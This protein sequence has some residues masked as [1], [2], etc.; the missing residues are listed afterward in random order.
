MD[1][2]RL[3]QC[4][5]EEETLCL[6]M[7]LGCI[8]VDPGRVPDVRGLHSTLRGESCN[9]LGQGTSLG[10]V[11]G[12]EGF[13]ERGRDQKDARVQGVV[14]PELFTDLR[15]SV[16]THSHFRSV[17]QIEAGFDPIVYAE[18]RLLRRYRIRGHRRKQVR[19]PQVIAHQEQGG[20]RH[21]V[22]RLQQRGAVGLLVLV[23]DDECELGLAL[24]L[25]EAILQL[26]G[27]V[28]DD[29]PDLAD[30]SAFEGPDDTDDEFLA[31][32]LGINHPKGRTT[33]VADL[34]HP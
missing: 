30:T 16:A 34:S 32:R 10:T 11:N 7:G 5:V 20:P 4:S 9:P 8:D 22:T 3:F 6:G 2:I 26:V 33:A 24:E 29:D 12:V 19:R 1:P 21:E 14:V 13:D 28:P 18:N 23:V 25:G 15:D 31:S 17:V 27:E